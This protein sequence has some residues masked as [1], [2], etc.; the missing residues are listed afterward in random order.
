MQCSNGHEACEAREVSRTRVRDTVEDVR[1]VKQ[2]VKHFNREGSE[3]YKEMA[4]PEFV[5]REVEFDRVE[6]R[7]DQC[8]RTLIASENEVT[9]ATQAPA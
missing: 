9:L 7:C 4:M 1:Y 8:G 2:M 5:E 6:Y 3:F